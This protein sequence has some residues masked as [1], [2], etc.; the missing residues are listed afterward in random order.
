MFSTRVSKLATLISTKGD[1]CKIFVSYRIFI[2]LE[3]Y[4]MAKFGLNFAPWHGMYG[5]LNS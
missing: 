5:N 2:C 3:K 1:V 4:N